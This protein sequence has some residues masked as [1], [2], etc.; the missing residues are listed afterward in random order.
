[1]PATHV[2]R[3]QGTRCVVTGRRPAGSS[4]RTVISRSPKMVMATVR[5][6][7]VAVMTSRWGVSRLPVAGSTASARSRRASRWATPKRCCS[8]TTTSPRR[9]IW[10]V[11]DSRACV[12][13]TMTGSPAASSARIRRRPEAGVEPVSRWTR[14]A[15]SAPPSMPAPARGPRSEPSEAWCWA[16]RTSVGASRAA[17]PPPPT[18]CS[19]ARRATS[20][21]P[22]PTSPWRRRCMGTVE[23]SAAASSEPTRL[24][25]A[26]SAKGRAA[27]RSERRESGPGTGQATAVRV[28]SCSARRRARAT[29]RTKASSWR[30]RRRAARHCPASS[31]R[32]TQR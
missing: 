10:T 11:S 15:R 28:A 17:W 3:S 26:V 13:T 27:S 21:L 25:P 6:M 8:S 1:M 2:S 30:R 5:G 22:E 12:P 29:W 24:C 32:W 31:G 19:M 23:S 4:S 9:G 20:V 7:G 18:T 14:V 16:A